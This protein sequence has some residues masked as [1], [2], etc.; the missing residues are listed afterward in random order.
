MLVDW[1]D[2]VLRHRADTE[3]KHQVRVQGPDM[4]SMKCT[5]S[6]PGQIITQQIMIRLCDSIG[7]LIGI[8]V[9]SN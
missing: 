9:V 4:E 8:K 7:R 6:V 5:L 2:R 3:C 1:L